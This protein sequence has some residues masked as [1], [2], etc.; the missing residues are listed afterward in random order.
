MDF[1]ICSDKIVKT[2]EIMILLIQL[3]VLTLHVRLHVTQGCCIIQF[4]SKTLCVSHTICTQFCGHLDLCHDTI[5]VISMCMCYAVCLL[6]VIRIAHKRCYLPCRS[7]RLSLTPFWLCFHHRIIT[8]FQKWCS[9]KRS[10][11]NER[12]VKVTEVITQHSCFQTVSPVWIHI[13]WWNDA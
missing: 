13:W 2:T 3:I 5:K 7:V 4:A 12:K 6:I 9:C 1:H 8:K 11:S 10:R